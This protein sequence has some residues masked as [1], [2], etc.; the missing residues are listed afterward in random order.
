M[1][2]TPSDSRHSRHS[3]HSPHSLL[4]VAAFPPELAGFRS[5]LGDALRGRIGG[6]AVVA[7]TVGIGLPQAAVGAVMAIAE[8]KT[9]AVVLVGTCGAYPGSGLG[10]G[11]VVVARRVLLVDPSVVDGAAQFPGPMSVASDAD[12]TLRGELLRAGAVAAD[13]ATTL[14]VTVDDEVA[15]RTARGAGAQVEHLEAHG[16][17]SACATLGVPFAA[18][19]GV[20]NV[21][22]SR[23]REEW[24]AHH[25]AAGEAAVRCVI[26]WLEATSSGA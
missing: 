15:G 1:L 21:V 10:V 23:G 14:A 19:L 6:R 24:Q 3:R 7:R 17:A 25:R 2:P 18:V 13:V 11:D 12:A 22:G 4:V 8:A 5:V 16:V 9:A 20:A 26:A